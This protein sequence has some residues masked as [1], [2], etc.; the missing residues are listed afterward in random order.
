M[1][2]AQVCKW[3]PEHCVARAV[4]QALGTGWATAT[5]KAHSYDDSKRDHHAHCGIPQNGIAAD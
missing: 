3:L 2:A 4:V 1:R 5:G